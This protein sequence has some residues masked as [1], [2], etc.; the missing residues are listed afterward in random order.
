MRSWI[1]FF[2]AGPQP[3]LFFTLLSAWVWHSD[4]GNDREAPGLV[5]SGFGDHVQ[6]WD[7]QWL[8]PVSGWDVYINDKGWLPP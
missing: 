4:R 1:S 7:G 3:H 5:G 2:L 8:L 6:T